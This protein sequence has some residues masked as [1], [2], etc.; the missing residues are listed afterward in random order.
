MS[1]FQNVDHEEE[2]GVNLPK[3]NAMMIEH[4]IIGQNDG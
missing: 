3:R 1:D 4:D 2:E